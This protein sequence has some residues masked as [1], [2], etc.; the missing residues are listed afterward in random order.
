MPTSFSPPPTQPGGDVGVFDFT[1]HVLNTNEVRNIELQ[2]LLE[3]DFIKGREHRSGLPVRDA[4]AMANAV[5]DEMYGHVVTSEDDKRENSIIALE[6][7]YKIL[8]NAPREEEGESEEL[9]AA[10]KNLVSTL[11]GYAK[12]DDGYVQNNIAHLG[13]VVCEAPVGRPLGSPSGDKI[14]TTHM[15]RF[16][17]ANDDIIFTYNHTPAMKKVLRRAVW[18]QANSEMITSRRPSLKLRIAQ[19][20]AALLGQI[21]AALPSADVKAVQQELTAG[22][23]TDTEEAAS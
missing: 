9:T 6:L 7:F 17:T 23:A 22:P 10:R 1:D 14:G 8:P 3:H 16:L 11:W 20:E 5:L 19:S 18:L 21:R 13:M 4:K 15:G 12:P 2:I